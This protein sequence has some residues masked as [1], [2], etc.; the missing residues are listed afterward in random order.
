MAYKR[1]IVP[2]EHIESKILVIRTQKAMLDID[3]AALYD[4]QF[5]IVFDAIRELMTSPKTERRRIG[6]EV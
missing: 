5:K 1:T 3:R 6:F 4:A 2:V